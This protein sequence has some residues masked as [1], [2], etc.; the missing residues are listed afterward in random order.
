M[1]KRC[2]WPLFVFLALLTGT[3]EAAAPENDPP[4]FQG[5]NRPFT[6]L[7]PADQA[8]AAPIYTLTGGVTTLNHF[9]GKVVLLNLWATWCPACVH[10]LPTLGNLQATLGGNRFTVVALAIDEG[11]AKAVAAYL[12]KLKLDTLPVYLDPAGRILDALKV[13]NALPL[14]VVIDHQGRMMGYMKGAADWSSPKA[15]ALIGYYIRRIS[16]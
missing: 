1:T 9:A 5:V 10:E 15:K 13:G 8:P 2:R 7:T 16:P 14:S 3:V 12:K 4:A 11:G 6:L